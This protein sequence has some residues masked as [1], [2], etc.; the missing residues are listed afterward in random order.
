ME[1]LKA[2]SSPS[3]MCGGDGAAQLPEDATSTLY[4]VHTE[5]L[6]TQQKNI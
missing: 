2:T 6:C 4:T 1:L 3:E 5:I